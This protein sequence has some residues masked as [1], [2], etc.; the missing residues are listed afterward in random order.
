MLSNHTM[1][2]IGEIRRERL[3]LL[4]RELGNLSFAEMNARM[5][6]IRRDAT[7]SQVA[8]ASPNTRTGRPRQMGD[9]QA[10]EIE[11]VF[12]KPEGWMDRDPE[13]DALEA[14]VKSLTAQEPTAIYRLWPFARVTS[15]QWA[16]ITP[17]QRAAVEQL[18]LS[19]QPVSETAS[20]SAAP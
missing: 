18:I 17:P 13:I 1:K 10:R 16:A 6:R 7:L 5:G 4:R 11:R 20:N 19:L 9:D 14:R 2:V 12:G 3:S 15:D 8:K